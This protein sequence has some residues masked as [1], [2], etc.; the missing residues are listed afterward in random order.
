MCSG[1]A[2]KVKYINHISLL[3]NQHNEERVRANNNNSVNK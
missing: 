2:I 3:Y 1:I